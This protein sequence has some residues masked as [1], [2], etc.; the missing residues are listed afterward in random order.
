[1]PWRLIAGP[2]LP[3]SE[4][5][6][7]QAE[8]AALGEAAGVPAVAVERF[9]SDFPDLLGQAALSVSQAG[10]NTVLDILAS[11]VR[12]VVVPYEGSG[13]EQP[14]RARLLAERNLLQVV[15]EGELSP[16]RLASAVAEAIATPDFPA[17]IRLDMDGARRSVEILAALVDEVA[18]ARGGV[19]PRDAGSQRTRPVRP[20]R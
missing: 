14:L 2:Y 4:Y 18:A 1:M 6:H 11:G 13:D 3:E 12:A 19:S 17:A 8:A 20:V 16:A 7:L 15:A 5:A 9:R 10:Y